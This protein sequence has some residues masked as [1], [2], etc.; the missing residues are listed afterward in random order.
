V[1]NG[2]VGNFILKLDTVKYGL[3]MSAV[4][5]IKYMKT[6]FNEDNILST[7]MEITN[8]DDAK[9]YLN[10][11]IK[12]IQKFIDSDDNRKNESAEETAKGNLGYYAGYYS[13]DVRERV[14]ELFGCSHPLFGTIKENGIPTPKQAFEIG[15]K[16]SNR[17]LRMKKMK[18]I[19]NEN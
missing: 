13:N 4:L 2:I 3:V 17:I 9:Q 10:E 11:Y 16:Y 12:H 8:K 1:R 19:N 6:K 5:H 18:K 7:A 14:E 15:I